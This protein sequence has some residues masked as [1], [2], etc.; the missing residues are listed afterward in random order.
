[1]VVGV[2]S[3]PNRSLKLHLS[4]S[5]AP[6]IIQ[7]KYHHKLKAKGNSRVSLVSLDNLM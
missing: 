7:A 4:S 3:V 5:I 2:C 6:Y 1:M